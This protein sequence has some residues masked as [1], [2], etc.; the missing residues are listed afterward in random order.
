MSY[1]TK[2]REL[3]E[4]LRECEWNHPIDAASTCEN[5]ADMIQKYTEMLIS[6][7]GLLDDTGYSD[8]ARDVERW[9]DVWEQVEDKPV[10]DPDLVDRLAEPSERYDHNANNVTGT[11]PI[12][13]ENDLVPIQLW[14]EQ[15]RTIERLTQYES[16]MH[17]LC[18]RINQYASNKGTYQ[19]PNCT[20]EGMRAALDGVMFALA[21]ER[22]EAQRKLDRIRSNEP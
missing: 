8:E 14:R 4:S 18:D 20:Y 19:T 5:A 21:E 16:D 22:N 3:A 15:H 6:Y 2:L 1:P 9:I 7:I 17:A 12:D 11:Y 10:T 13:E